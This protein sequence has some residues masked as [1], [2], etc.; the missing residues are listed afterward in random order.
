MGVIAK[1]GQHVVVDG[2]GPDAVGSALHLA[3][4]GHRVTLAGPDPP[5][6]REAL[7]SVGIE[8]LG[9][10]DLDVDGPTG[11]VFVVDCWTGETAPRVRRHRSAG[12]LVT[13]IGDL[14]LAASSRPAVGVTGSAGKTTATRLAA[15]L[16]RDGGLTVAESASARGGNAWPATELLECP[17][18][19]GWLA[20]ELTSTHLAYMHRSPE[21]AVVTGFWADHIE[22]H[23]DLDAYRAAKRAILD[24]QDPGGT[25]VLNADD[26]GAAGF[27]GDAVGRVLSVSS[28]TSVGDGIGVR[29]GRLVA[30]IDGPPVDLG[31]A[32]DLAY[33]GPLAGVA[34]AA[35]CAAL[36]A[37]ADAEAV[38][39]G[40]REPI[41]LVHRRRSLGMVNGVEVVD[42]TAAT[43]PRKARAALAE[44]DAS[45]V[46]AIVGGSRSIAGAPVHQ[47][48]GERR[49]LEAALEAYARCRVVVA[50]GPAGADL[51]STTHAATLADAC[52]EAR[53][54]ARPGDAILVAPMFPVAIDERSRLAEYLG[55]GADT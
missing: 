29:R 15:R 47:S 17:P 42:D 13:S 38:S 52:A 28:R 7:E 27:A 26:P 40:L 5:A 25:C 11:A 33:R 43:T 18:V 6:D 34:L 9:G 14:V 22:L 30:R 12:A 19:E 36:V 46:V 20:V 1:P 2:F 35:A 51:P 32:T 24:H 48:D 50:F 31:A 45:R 54:V 10:V 16:M 39:R 37:G 53:R 55:L 21:I 8:V 41:V 49:E 44:L 23:G 3:R 4:L